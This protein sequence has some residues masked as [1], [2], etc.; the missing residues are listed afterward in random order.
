MRDAE[1]AQLPHP[2]RRD[3]GRRHRHHDGELR[4]RLRP[5]GHRRVHLVRH[6]PRPV[7]EVR[8]ALRRRRAPPEEAAQPPRPHHRGRRGAQAP[9]EAGRG[10][11][12]RSATCSA[13]ARRCAP[14]ATRPTAPVVLGTNPDYAEANVHFVQD[15]RFITDADVSHARARLRDRPRRRRRALPAARPD[16]PASSRSTAR[17]YQVVGALR[18]RRAAFFG[19][20]NDN[21][22]AIPITRLRRAVPARSRTAAATPS[23]SPPCRSRPEDFDALIEE[24]TAILRARR[25]LRPGQPNDFAIFT[26]VGQ[27][28]QFQQITGGV[29]AAMLVIAGDRAAGRRR[30]RDEHHAGQ[31]HPADARDRPAQGARRHPPRHRARSS[32]SR[33]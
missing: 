6:P 27:L 7:P 13:T 30:R 22:V 29:A 15:G 14:G 1:A 28:R 31:R 12:A 26:S 33:R 8:A 23:T 19:G 20:S 24:E 3:G 25:G 11:L 10:G 9:V 5:P 16:R 17:A 32:S 4:R 21:F 2:A 18:A